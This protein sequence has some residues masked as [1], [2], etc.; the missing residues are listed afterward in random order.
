MIS[1]EAIYFVFLDKRI[2]LEDGV[3]SI[4]RS[5]AVE[6]VGQEHVKDCHV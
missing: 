2:Y 4:V 1:E 5:K 6:F 3:R